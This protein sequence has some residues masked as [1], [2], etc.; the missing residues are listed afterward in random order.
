MS[1]KEK[2]KK[3]RE[4]TLQ[5]LNKEV[6][7]PTSELRP[8][9][10]QESVKA[11]EQIAE[12]IETSVNEAPSKPKSTTVNEYDTI[13]P[14][15]DNMALPPDITV[16]SVGKRKEVE[17]RLEELAIDDLFTLG[18]LRQH[19][20]IRPNRLEVTFRTLK[21][22]E[23]LY[24]KKRLN[25]VR[26]DVVRYAEDRFVYMLLCAHIHAYNGK[27]FTPIMKNGEVDPI[28]FDKRFED[29]CNIPNILIE[30]IWVHYRWFEDRVKSALTT[31]NLKGG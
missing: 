22:A 6:S 18:E 1:N 21:G 7:K 25:E 11:L 24:I 14:L 12:Q 13:D 17:G 16:A 30:E 19:V 20:P 29:L 5:H 28:S 4:S 10:S 9:L 26:N 15:F 2:I 31:D 3:A 27:E 8:R 23:D